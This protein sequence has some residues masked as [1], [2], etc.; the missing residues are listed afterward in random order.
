MAEDL[1][2]RTELPTE[3][4]RS[5]ARQRG[6]VARSIELS[7]AVIL[8]AAVAVILIFA[9]AMLRGLALL[10]RRLLSEESL[11]AG[12]TVDSLRPDVLAGGWEA[13]RLAAPLMLAMVLVALA[14]GLGQVGFIITT[15]PLVPKWNKL[16]FIT[17]FSKLLNKRALVKGA[18]D[19]FKLS[20]ILTVV[21]LVVR[22]HY[23]ELAALSNLGLLAASAEGA[24]ICRD[25]AMWVLLVLLIMGIVDYSYQRWQLTRDL[26][27]TRSE[28]KDER[29]STEGDPEVK[30][31]RLRMARQI[32]MQRL[33]VD[34]PRA[35]V[36]VTN[37]TH[38]A[39]AIRYDADAG[40]NAPKVVAKGADYLAMKI[41]YIAA[42]HGVPIVERPPLARALYNDVPVGRE[43]RAEHF[44][45]VAEVL[46]YVYRLEGRLAG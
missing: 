6:Q 20:L 18:I 41:R 10:T 25:V 26:R 16:N 1:G 22:S 45:A 35:D 34:V 4:R 29:K 15:E 46:A 44:E 3:R 13:L 12:L 38:Y 28:V 7:A 43:I 11:G 23:A 19:L 8:S 37:P 40:M 5:E 9:E 30:A 14:S 17:N 21:V 36:I 32:A 42:A 2:E 31:R 27:M 39:V 24:R 33:G